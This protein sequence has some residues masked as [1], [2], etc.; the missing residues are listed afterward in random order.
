MSALKRL[1]KE[2]KD[3]NANPP[4]NCSAGPINH[5]DM[6]HWQATMLGPGDSPYQGGVFFFD[7]HFPTD[8]P[9]KP[10][11]IS[12]TTK[13]FH[14][15]L[16]HN[17]CCET[18]DILGNQWSPALTIGKVLLSIYSIL[19]DPNPDNVCCTHGNMEIA[20]IYKKNRAQYESTAKEWTKKYAC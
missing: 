18:L 2:L 3:F 15:N 13:I 14:P 5:S 9:F 8:Y 19:K 4:A 20:N 16:K 11:K 17:I 6:F 1:Q 10:P 7:I 12:I